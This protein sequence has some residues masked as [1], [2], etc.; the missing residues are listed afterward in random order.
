[1]GDLSETIW[2]LALRPLRP[3]LHLNNA[4]GCQIWQSSGL[5]LEPPTHIF[6]LPFDK[7]VLRNH[8]TNLEYYISTSKVFMATKFR[9]MV[10]Y[11]KGLLLT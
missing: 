11:V 5:L 8:M 10:T 3:Y 9:R 6:T 1:M 4:Y 2:N 7:V